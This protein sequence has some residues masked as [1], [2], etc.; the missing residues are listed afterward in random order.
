M[1]VYSNKYE[2]DDYEVAGEA[3]IV[4]CQVSPKTLLSSAESLNAVADRPILGDGLSSE[5]LYDTFN[6]NDH[7]AIQMKM[8]RRVKPRSILWTVHIK[9]VIQ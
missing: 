8:S 6:M 7:R 2:P 9:K 5:R 1:K 4:N 3:G